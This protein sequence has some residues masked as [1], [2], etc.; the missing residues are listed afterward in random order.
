M[1]QPEASPRRS[2][3]RFLLGA[4]ALLLVLIVVT[5][6]FRRELAETSVTAYLEGEGV[7]VQSLAVTRLTLQTIELRDLALGE[8][9]ELT[10][11]SVVLTPAIDGFDASLQAARIDGLRLTLDITG[12]KPL[13]GSLQPALDRLM[14]EAEGDDSAEPSAPA[15]PPALPEVV[16]ADA[17][18]VFQTPSGPMTAAL[19]GTLTPD[20]AGGA[21]LQAALRLDSALGRL[22]A[23]LSGRRS[24]TGAI[25]LTAEVAEGRLAWQDFSRGAFSGRLT[26]EQA[27]GGAPQLQA[28]FDL[29]DL[30]YTPAGAAPLQLASG[31]LKASG[32]LARAALA[33]SLAG[34]NEHLDLSIEA[35]QNPAAEGQVVG[36]DVQG[37]VRT[38]GG[39]AQFLPLPG[40][41]VT[42]GTLVVE[43]AGDG[44][45]SG[46]MTQAATWRD[47]PTR[48]AE[49]RVRLEGD[50][51]LGAVTLADGTTGVSA[52]LPLIVDFTDDRATV[53]LSE[54]AAVR[55]EQPARDSLHQLGVPDDLLP[56]LVSGLNLTLAAGGE[57]PFRLAATPIWPPRSVVV[58][59][60]AQAASDQGLSLALRA[61]GDATLDAALALAGYA[62]SLDARAEAERVA[63]GG[64]EA[65]GVALTL[66]LA[67]DYG[68]GGLNLALARPGTLRTARFGAKTPLQLSAPLAF[69]IGALNLTAAP[70]AAGYR[71]GLSAREDGAAF[72]IA[73]AGS[74]PVAVTAGALTVQ[75]DGSFDPQDGHA[76][77]LTARLGGLELPGYGFDAEAV[78]IEVALDRELRPARSRFALGP[79]QLGSDEA[80]LRLDGSLQRSG[81]GYDIAGE[82]AASEG[83]ILVDLT[84]RYGDDGRASLKAVSRLISF[85]PDGLQPA[86]L[87]PLLADLEAVSGTL[88]AAARLAW[89]RD[90]AA[91]SGRLTLSNLAFKSQGTEVAGLN[92][93]VEFDSLL[94]LASAA[95][96]RLTIRSLDAGVLL[97]AIDLVFSLDQAPRPR[98][99]LE[100]GGFGL[101][102]ARWKIEPTVLD[103]AA[104][105]NRVVLATDDLDLA[106]FFELIGVDGLSGSG[107]LA[108]SLP[109]V[110]AGSDIIVEDGHF[111]ALEPGRLSIRFQAL[112]SA[113]AGGGETVDA[114]VK[115]LEDFHYEELSLALAKTAENDATV[116]LSTLGQNPEV[117]EGQPF[118]FNINLESNLTSVL[119]ALQQGYSLSDDALKRAW[120]LR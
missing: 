117:M 15:R 58:A 99:N 16:L 86:A 49:S 27:P 60:T 1:S 115:A 14:V 24:A 42:A 28:D 70:A 73:A 118:R 64:R 107:R 116:K 103:P 26:V 96:Q 101:G 8:A 85:A 59:V 69:E 21:A 20:T 89:P 91:E 77:S 81:A 67:A 100:D 57:L 113:L 71:Y 62:G 41:K 72:T 46:D 90:P 108:G 120:R 74:E 38:A 65:Q 109:I 111:D 45:L 54:D 22:Q 63:L 102:G 52:H 6:L 10:I 80:P 17:A 31:A 34:D 23:Q 82:L 37:E 104:A 3:R 56:L 4:T 92:L 98:L 53:A 40:P 119:E 83:P 55:V 97:E 93:D 61:E 79:M 2:R 78:E 43:A 94:P 39:L 5:V 88:T 51:I 47:L 75:L 30:A 68:T 32:S 35:E 13:L 36:L 105:Q 114:A 48:L 110:F 7:T 25:S 87:S 19:D 9:G 11:A 112:R 106:T 29:R 66:P 95:G 18:V 50:A 76:A 84:G 33:L 12:D 44:R